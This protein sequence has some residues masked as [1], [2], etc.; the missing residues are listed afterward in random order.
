[1]NDILNA[2]RIRPQTARK[3]IWR[4]APLLILLYV[5]NQMD[6]ANVGYAA[7]TMNRELGMSVSQFGFAT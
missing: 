5:V 7:L 4:L 1:M 3:V 2:A 6:R